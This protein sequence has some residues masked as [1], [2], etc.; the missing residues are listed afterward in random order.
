MHDPYRK[1]GSSAGSHLPHNC[2]APSLSA[3]CPNTLY[4]PKLAPL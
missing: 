4:E 3:A 2:L 1:A